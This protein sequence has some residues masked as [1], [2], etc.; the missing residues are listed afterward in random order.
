MSL[1]DLQNF[2]RKL[3]LFDL[4]HHVE[5]QKLYIMEH[6]LRCFSVKSVD[7]NMKQYQ[8]VLTLTDS[9]ELFTSKGWTVTIIKKS[10]EECHCGKQYDLCTCGS[11]EQKF[12]H[13]SW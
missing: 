11:T 13:I 1:T 12:Y 5:R 6:P 3:L 4:N 2:W 9:T 7:V 8:Y 10:I